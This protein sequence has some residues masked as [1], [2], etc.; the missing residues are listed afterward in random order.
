VTAS[1]Q[2]EPLDY[3]ER[4]MVDS[5]RVLRPSFVAYQT[6]VDMTQAMA[7]LEELRRAGVQAT[8]THLLVRA[9]AKALASNPAL[10]QAVVGSRRYRNERVDIGLSVTGDTAVAPVLVLE[11]ADQKSVAELA[12]ETARR[13]PLVREAQKEQLR[14]LRR[15]GWLLPFGFLRRAVMRL[16]FSRGA[17]RRQTAGTFQVSTVP[18][19]WAATSVFV[20]SGVLVGGQ[21]WSRVVAVDGQPAVRPIM[22]LTLSGDHSVWDGRAAARFLAT[23]KGELERR[24]V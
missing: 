18:L 2:D 4:W 6:T 7:Q 15:W 21:V 1:P 8:A 14:S 13:A 24:A 23:V 12:E 3:A 9:A 5:L 10:H 16:L 11:G 17:F 20:A 19:D 22:T